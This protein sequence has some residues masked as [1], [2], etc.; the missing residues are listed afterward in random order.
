MGWVLLVLVSALLF[1]AANII[2]KHVLCKEHAL[3]FLAARGFF[4]L[5]LILLFAPWVNF[6]LPARSLGLIF[7]ASM[8]ATMGYYSQ[9]HVQ[10]H[11]E[12]SYFSPIQNLSPIVLLFVAVLFLQESITLVQLLGI[13]AIVVGSTILAFEP[14]KL[15]WEQLK[16]WKQPYWPHFLAAIV[17]LA[18]AVA[19]DKHNL[20]F[21]N[22]VTYMFFTLLFM[23][24]SYIIIDAFKYNWSH[25]NED[26]RKGWHWLV[27]TAVLTVISLLLFYEALGM[28]DVLV[29]VALPLRRASTL[30]ETILGG[31]LF[32]EKFQTRRIFACIITLVGIVL[33][34]A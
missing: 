1:A 13:G 30:L 7:I 14:G 3:E 31:K 9:T 28:P 22:P 32:N 18:V 19:L 8:I 12:I 5:V 21:V 10:R 33:L 24:L 11:T 2:R 27:F 16:L 34:A 20:G 6:S 4:I 26:L 17:L 29:S 23:N 25:I 15:T